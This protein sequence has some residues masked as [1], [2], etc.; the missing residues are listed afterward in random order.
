MY[1]TLTQGKVQIQVETEPKYTDFVYKNTT[2]YLTT[3]PQF[4]YVAN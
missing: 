3:T 1:I 4:S 2:S